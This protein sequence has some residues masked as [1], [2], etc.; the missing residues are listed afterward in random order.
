[1]KKGF[2]GAVLGLAGMAAGVVAGGVVSTR[3]SSKKI[4]ELMEGHRKVHALYMDR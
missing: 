4:N 1:M 3:A 2:R